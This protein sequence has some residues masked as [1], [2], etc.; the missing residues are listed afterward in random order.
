MGAGRLLVVAGEA[1]GRGLVG[2]RALPA[3]G[4]HR[5]R[6][7]ATGQARQQD[8]PGRPGI[9][10]AVLAADPE[11]AP[12]RT[13]LGVG[14]DPDAWEQ[15]TQVGGHP[16]V[17]SG[18]A[19]TEFRVLAEALSRDVVEEDPGVRPAALDPGGELQEREDVVPVHRAVA[20]RLTVHHGSDSEFPA[21]RGTP[22]GDAACAAT[23]AYG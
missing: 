11:G 21:A 6:L 15:G 10:G 22:A 20:A 8:V 7:L 1:A 17:R 5:P 13:R 14:V 18:A 12:V 9:H 16:A 4:E 19:E 3:E 2:D 23:D